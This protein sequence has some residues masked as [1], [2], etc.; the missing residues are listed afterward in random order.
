MSK[1]TTQGLDSAETSPYRYAK[2]SLFKD[3]LQSCHAMVPVRGVWFRMYVNEDTLGLFIVK[4]VGGG[5]YWFGKLAF[6]VS[7]SSL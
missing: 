6:M 7:M 3:L 2:V 4:S 5:R 1:L